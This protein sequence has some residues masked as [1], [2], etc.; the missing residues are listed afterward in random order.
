MI[1]QHLPQ[2]HVKDYIHASRLYYDYNYIDSN[3][4]FSYRESSGDVRRLPLVLNI[5]FN[6]KKITLK[7][8]WTEIME[9]I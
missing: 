3:A 5:Q 2:R 9:K 4:G 1:M 6:A 7:S 8:L